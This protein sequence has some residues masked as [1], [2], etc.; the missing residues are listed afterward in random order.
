[1]QLGGL[2]SLV[3]AYP[4]EETAK[5]HNQPGVS[6]YLTAR[7]RRKLADALRSCPSAIYCDTDSIHLPA[8]AAPPAGIGTIPGDW[9]A[10]SS[11]P[12]Y[13]RGRRSYRLG[14]KVVGNPDLER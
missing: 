8:D 13:Y 3:M 6:S 12:A 10:K 7:V 14:S 2:D 4:V 9:A 11:G 5:P 1:V